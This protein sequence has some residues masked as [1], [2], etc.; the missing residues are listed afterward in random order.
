MSGFEMSIIDDR[1]FDFDDEIT[2]ATAYRRALARL[3]SRGRFHKIGEDDLSSVAGVEEVPAP[4]QATTEEQHSSQTRSASS[5]GESRNNSTL[6]GTKSSATTTS[7][8]FDLG[9]PFSATMD[10]FF[11]P[12]RPHRYRDGT[13]VTLHPSVFEPNRPLIAERSIIDPVTGEAFDKKKH[14]HPPSEAQ[15]VKL[16]Q[17]AL[18]SRG[19]QQMISDTGRL[20]SQDQIQSLMK[21]DK[22]R[23]GFS[24]VGGSTVTPAMLQKDPANVRKLKFV[25]LGD[26]AAGKTYAVMKYLRGHTNGIPYAPTV[27]A[28][29]TSDI[30]IDGYHCQV[31]WEDTTGQDDYDR[32]RPIAYPDCH[33]ALLIFAIDSPDSL[34]N[35]MAKWLIEINQYHPSIPK[36]LV[37]C[38]I[39]LRD[40]P[41]TI[42]ELAKTSQKPVTQL[43]GKQLASSLNRDSR[44]AGTKGTSN[45]QVKYME[46]SAFTGEGIKELFEEAAQMGIA[47]T[48]ADVAKVLDKKQRR[49]SSLFRRTKVQQPF[50]PIREEGATEGSTNFRVENSF[51]VQ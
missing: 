19:V 38:K 18:A 42:K 28:N 2:N 4:S 49:I 26:G 10:D 45:G 21:E 17:K 5:T 39:D 34:A 43:Q 46:C 3:R 48:D 47:Y 23:F 33:V 9:A 11:V 12:T 15:M 41:H 35:I 51:H 7:I 29:Y 6:E 30:K 1:Q 27:Y 50:S 22:G 32:L 44:R 31:T 25:I 13:L 37:G 8:T 40:D 24:D 36:I 16:E 20:K 14:S